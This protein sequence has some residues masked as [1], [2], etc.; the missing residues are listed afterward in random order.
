M[1]RTAYFF[2][3]DARACRYGSSSWTTETPAAKRS[4][5]SALTA[6]A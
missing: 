3:S 5:I 6:S 2:A 1:A 4:R